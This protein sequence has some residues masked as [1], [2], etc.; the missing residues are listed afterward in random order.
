[1]I[2]QK[3]RAY[4][5][6]EEIKEINQLKFQICSV[7]TSVAKKKQTHYLLVIPRMCIR[8]MVDVV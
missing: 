3:S 4:V 6:I 1:M 2:V 5:L 8:D 7:T